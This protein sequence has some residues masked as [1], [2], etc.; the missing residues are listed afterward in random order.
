M[1][2]HSTRKE[3]YTGRQIMYNK[4]YRVNLFAGTSV[5]DNK[6]NKVTAVVEKKRT[7]F[8]GLC[9][10]DQLTEDS[11]KVRGTVQ[12]RQELLYCIYQLYCIQRQTDDIRR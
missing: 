4:H 8:P 2:G 7:A 12:K 6:E 10:P 11:S 9:I 3:F 1:F 5:D